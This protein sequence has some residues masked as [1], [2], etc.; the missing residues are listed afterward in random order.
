MC[1]AFKLMEAHLILVILWYEFAKVV[2]EAILEQL[3]K[4]V[5]C[6][7]SQLFFKLS[8]TLWMYILASNLAL[9]S[10][11]NDCRKVTLNSMVKAFLN[12]AQEVH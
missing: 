4:F 3:R 8:L 2:P 12:Y 9:I 6:F 10:S 11:T 1:M 7:R 5:N